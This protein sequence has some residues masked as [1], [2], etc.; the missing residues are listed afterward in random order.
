MKDKVLKLLLPQNLVVVIGLFA[1]LLPVFLSQYARPNDSVS[2]N[3]MNR[4]PNAEVAK[5]NQMPGGENPA[6]PKP[7]AVMKVSKGPMTRSDN[8]KGSVP[9]R[10]QP[11]SGDSVAYSASRYSGM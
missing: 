10:I 1:A 4:P 3:L 5:E 8:D 7:A 11:D 6:L 9:Q 2:S